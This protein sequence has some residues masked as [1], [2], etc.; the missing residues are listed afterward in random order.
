MKAEKQPWPRRSV[1]TSAEAVSIWQRK[2]TTFTSASSSTDLLNS[3]NCWHLLFRTSK[4]FLV[5]KT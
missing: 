5:V 2:D 3:N 1:H 4:G